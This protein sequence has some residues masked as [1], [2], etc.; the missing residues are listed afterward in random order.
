[1]NFFGILLL[2]VTIFITYSLVKKFYYARAVLNYLPEEVYE[3]LKNDKNVVLLD[4]RTPLEHKRQNIEGS[5]NIPLHE[6]NNRINELEEYKDK[7]I[8]CYCRSGNRSLT[9]AFKLY[10]KGY[11]PAN[12]K[13]G[14]INWNFSNK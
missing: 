4:V 14:I 7:E 2:L 5:L 12:M 13:G 8:I 11:K 6:L 9:A 1:M 10:N 3:K